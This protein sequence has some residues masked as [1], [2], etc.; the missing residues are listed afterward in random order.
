MKLSGK[1]N[2][3]LETIYRKKYQI[4]AFT[5]NDGSRRM[6]K[7]PLSPDQLEEIRQEILSRNSNGF[8][9]HKNRS[10]KRRTSRMFHL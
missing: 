10:E 7:K 1:S 9:I 6:M 2:T 8:I 4:M 5:A 3:H